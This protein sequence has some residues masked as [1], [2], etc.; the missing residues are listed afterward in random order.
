MSVQY[1]LDT[2]HV[3]YAIRGHGNVGHKI[4][5]HRPSEICI[6]ALTVAELRYGAD[7]RHSHKL[8][9]LIDIFTEN[10]DIMP[11]NEQAAIEYGRLAS[12]LV[13]RGTP[14]GQ[15]DTLIAA[16]AVSLGTT[17]VTNN[18][19]HFARVRGLTVENWA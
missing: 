3:S 16:H 19:K 11:F 15:L 4:L 8:H 17:L 9:G 12:H 18:M 14:I 7:R 6:S 5:A 10:I 1:M 13:G 2:D